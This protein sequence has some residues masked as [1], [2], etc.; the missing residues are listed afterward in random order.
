QTGQP[1]KG[2]VDIA[3]RQLDRLQRL[4]EELLDVS[5]IRT[6]RL[7]LKKATV[8][9]AAMVREVAGRFETEAASSGTT[10]TVSAE[11]SA[12]VTVDPIR[13]D[14]VITNL[15]SNALKFGAGKP[16]EVSLQIAEVARVSVRD[17]GIGIAAEE[18]P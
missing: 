16:I 11:G 3:L 13:I 7:T 2:M 8:D 10:L 12:L 4:T 1:P 6:G 9:L 18:Q 5:R 15:L 14:Q 17:H